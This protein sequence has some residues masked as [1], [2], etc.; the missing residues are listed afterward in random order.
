MCIQ[1]QRTHLIHRALFPQVAKD[2]APMGEEGVYLSAAVS[3]SLLNLKGLFHRCWCEPTSSLHTWEHM[4]SKVG[5]MKRNSSP[6]LHTHTHYT[7]Y[8]D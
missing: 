1:T 7:S 4:E 5:H 8:K 3:E 2:T 6:F